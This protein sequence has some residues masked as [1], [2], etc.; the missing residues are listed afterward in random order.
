MF[1][2]KIV[3]KEW[4]LILITILFGHLFF[5][6]FVVIIDPKESFSSIYKEIGQD[7]FRFILFTA[8]IVYI[9]IQLIRS[10]IWSIKV[11]VKKQI[12]K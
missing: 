1:N 7:P 11:I 5:A 3:A 4:L 10:I 12:K 9:L 2:K 6:T 8:A